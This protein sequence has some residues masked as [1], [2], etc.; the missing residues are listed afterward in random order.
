MCSIYSRCFTQAFS[1]CQSK[2][3]H[4]LSLLD[5]EI[6]CDANSTVEVQAGG[7]LFIHCSLFPHA[8]YSWTKDKMLVSGKESLVL[9]QVN[10]AHKGVYTLTVNT[11]A[12]SVYKEFI[13]KVLTETTSLS[14]DLVTLSLQ[15][16]KTETDFTQ[17]TGGNFTTS[18]TFG[19]ISTINTT[20][21][22]RDLTS[23]RSQTNNITTTL[24]NN[25][26]VTSTQDPHPFNSSTYQKLNTSTL[27]DQSAARNPFTTLSYNSTM[28]G[29]TQETR[30]DSRG[31]VTENADDPGPTPTQ[32]TGNTTIATKN[33]DT[34]GVRSHL[35]VLI[36]VLLL[37]LI[38][39]AGILYRRHIVKQRM[40]LP[41]SF[42]PPPPPVKY[43]AARQQEMST[44]HYPT[45]RCN[46][47]TEFEDVKLNLII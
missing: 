3:T 38:A 15:Y 44:Q 21:T 42:K 6:T 16:N 13:I 14:T 43:T 47:V 20:S 22:M 41:P 37:V 11:G 31:S 18:T 10:E 36:I 25:T 2:L 7:N 12:Q 27:S 40:D 35:V 29:P 4:I 46:S 30:N 34:A 8:Q 32:N 45:S 17:T 23:Y 1:G 28:F 5:V 24:P 9:W 33:G 26:H 39:V 19:M